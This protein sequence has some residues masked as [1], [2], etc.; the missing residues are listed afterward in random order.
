MS[1]YGQPGLGSPQGQEKPRS[2]NP[3]DLARELR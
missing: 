2:Q 1:G 3:G